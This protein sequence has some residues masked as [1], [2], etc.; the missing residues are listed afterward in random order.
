MQSAR[1]TTTET[2]GS[3]IFLASLKPWSAEH[4][5]NWSHRKIGNWTYNGDTIGNMLQPGM[6]SLEGAGVSRPAAFAV[7]RRLGSSLVDE[8]C[9]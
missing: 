2:L 9:S 7:R 1:A 3:G 6:P 8:E 5:S 4:D